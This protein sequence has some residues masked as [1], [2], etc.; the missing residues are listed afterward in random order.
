MQ[1][2]PASLLL[3]LR[4]RDESAWRRFVELYAPLLYFWACRLGLTGE[5]A[6]DLVQDVL[7]VLVE[8]MPSFE[9]DPS[10]KFRAFLRTVVENRWRDL[11]RRRAARPIQA[12]GDLD[13]LTAPPG[14]DFAEEEYRRHV[15]ARATRVMQADF[16][17]ATWRAFQA[18]VVE[19]RSAGE[20]AAEMG[21]SVAAVYQARA[22]V[23]RRLRQ[24]LADLLE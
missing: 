2:T 8:R 16:E 11:M 9:Y 13:G 18:V 21:L 24:E 15:L 22:R 12:G 10:R 20:V 5:D 7:L 14:S 23:L 6:S 19:E 1:D 3:R 4:S 17:P